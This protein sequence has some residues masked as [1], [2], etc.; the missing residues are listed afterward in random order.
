MYDLALD[1]TS[2]VANEIEMDKEV[3]G[4]RLLKPVCKIILKSG[5]SE[6]GSEEEGCM[7]W[8]DLCLGEDVRRG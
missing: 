4:Y 5:K 2:K 3:Q 6:R 7:F 1:S 8:Q